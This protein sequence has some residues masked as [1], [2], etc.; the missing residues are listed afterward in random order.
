MKKIILHKQAIED[1]EF[2]ADNDVKQL[3]RIIAL[4]VAINK[5]PFDGIGKPEPLRGNLQGFWSRRID[6]EHRVVYSVEGEGITKVS[7]R[8]HYNP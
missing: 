6:Q 1:L 4:I 8:F 5:N 3:K 7:C 2:W